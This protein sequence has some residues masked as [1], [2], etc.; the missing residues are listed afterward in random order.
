MHIS[1]F[2]S[3]AVIIFTALLSVAFLGRVIKKHMWI[4]MFTVL[5]G[6]LLVGMADILFPSSSTSDAGTNTNGIIAGRER[7]CHT[8]SLR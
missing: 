2:V 8:L 1:L 6:L 7:L 5:L 3:G 4:G